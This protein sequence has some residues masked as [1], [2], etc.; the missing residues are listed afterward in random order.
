MWKACVLCNSPYRRPADL[1]VSVFSRVC[2]QQRK[3]GR[4]RVARA[5]IAPPPGAAGRAAAPSYPQ[6]CGAGALDFVSFACSAW[7]TVCSRFCA[8]QRGVSAATPTR[9]AERLRREVEGKWRARPP[10]IYCGQRRAANKPAAAHR[11][12]YRSPPLPWQPFP[13]SHMSHNRRS[14]RHDH[15]TTAAGKAGCSAV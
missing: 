6:S 3:C 7:R 4:T 12:R 13:A 15:R 5:L 10:V 11:R 9:S 1:L 2:K 8:P 14:A